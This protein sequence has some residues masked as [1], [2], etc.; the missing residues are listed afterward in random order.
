VISQLLLPRCDKPGRIAAYEIMINTPAIS[1]LIRDNKTFRINSDIQT[2]GKYGMVTLDG[3]L[4]EKHM[5]GVISR[6][7]VMTKAQDVSTI[8][9]KLAEWEQAQA[10]AAA[11]Q[12]EG[13]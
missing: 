13:S 3:Y 2:G 10:E 4:M 7:E 5:Q 11:K 1:A 12:E 6:E 9:Q 8:V